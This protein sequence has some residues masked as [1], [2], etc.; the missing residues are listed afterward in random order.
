MADIYK[1]VGQTQSVEINPSGSGFAK[2]WEI[3]YQPTQGPHVGQ[4]YT[5]TVNDSDHNE[6][7]VDQAIR[8]KLK[9]INGIGNL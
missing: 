9:T 4:P 7:Y 6:K 5:L 1:I 2:V 3:T 8:D